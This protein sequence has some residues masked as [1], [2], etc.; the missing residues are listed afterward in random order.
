M[1]YEEQLPPAIWTRNFRKHILCGGA[2]SVEP[3]QPGG[4]LPGSGRREG[5][6][7]QAWGRGNAEAA[8]SET[9]ITSSFFRLQTL[10]PLLDPCVA[11]VL[12]TLKMG[13]WLHLLLC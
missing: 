10:W 4:G 5:M 3:C 7:R 6:G 11:L 13:Q 1:I 9:G 8:E 12:L 2:G